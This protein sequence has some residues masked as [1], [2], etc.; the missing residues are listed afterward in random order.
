MYHRGYTLL[1]LVDI[2]YFRVSVFYKISAF[3][4]VFCECF[5]SPEFDIYAPISQYLT[6]MSNVY[7]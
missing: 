7:M 4:W 5:W 6:N 2:R 3:L 1:K